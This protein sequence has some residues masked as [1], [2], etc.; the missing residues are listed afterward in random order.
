M[1]WIVV[2]NS[3]IRWSEEESDTYSLKDSNGN[4]TMPYNYLG[5]ATRMHKIMLP[6]I[7]LIKILKLYGIGYE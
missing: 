2:T 3:V 5:P 7:T 4:Y 1:Y 6:K